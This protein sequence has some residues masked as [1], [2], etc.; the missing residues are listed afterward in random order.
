MALISLSAIYTVLLFKYRIELLARQ[1]PY[2][3][4]LL[5]V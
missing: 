2:G 1:L 5:A 4:G 3:S